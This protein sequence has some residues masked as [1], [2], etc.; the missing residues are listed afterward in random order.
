[1]HKIYDKEASHGEVTCLALSNDETSLAA[2]FADG[3]IIVYKVQLVKEVGLPT[4]F[5]EEL[6]SFTLHRS[7]V[8]CLLFHK[9]VKS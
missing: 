3:S 1:M 6:H 5:S 7:D 4:V 8:T 9:N 2:G